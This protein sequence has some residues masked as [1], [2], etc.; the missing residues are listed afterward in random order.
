MIERELVIIGAG[1]AGLS[2]AIEAS[3]RNVDVLLIDENHKAGGQLFKQI[4]KFF[5]SGSHSAGVRGI[6]IGKELIKKSKDLGV[7]VWLNS[8]VI[9][10]FSNKKIA[11]EK[12]GKELQTVLAKKI[13]IATGASEKVINFEGWT[14]PGVMGAGAAQTMTNIHRVLPGKRVMMIGSGNVGLIVSYQ[15]IQAGAQIVGLVDAASQAG[16]YE[17]HYAKIERAGV[18][19]YLKHTILR[20]KGTKEKGVT[21]AVIAEVNNSWKPIKGTEKEFEVDVI[22]IAAGLKPLSELANM[23]SCERTY[24]SELGGWVPLHNENMESTQEGIYVVGDTT[25][26]EE[27]NTALEEGRLAGID[28][29]EKLE[30]LGLSDS[31]KIKEQ[32]NTRVKGLRL[33]PFGEGRLKAKKKL[34]KEYYKNIKNKNKSKDFTTGPKVV[35][36]CEQEI[37]C[38]PCETACKFGAITIGEPITNKPK[39]DEDKCIGCGLCLP[40]CPG[41]AIFLVDK[42]YN[43]KEGTVAFPYEFPNLPQKGE[44]VDALNRKGEYLCKAEVLKVKQLKSFDKTP[45]V[46]IIVPQKYVDQARNIRPKGAGH[47]ER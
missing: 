43:G 40:E 22:A 15:L 11:V 23:A 4:H 6:D 24:I 16:G 12:K 28:V 44:V 13:I 30:K 19:I 39:L 33:G 21:G 1:P 45:I 10:V 26:V 31:K 8:V 2:A 17:V 37:P 46:T 34:I 18:P 3:K 29:A 35:I 14:L 42:N 5:G 25:G 7:E 27:A 20:A 47:N 36:E 38:N 32:I 9:G 41:L